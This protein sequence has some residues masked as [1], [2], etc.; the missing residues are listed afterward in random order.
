MP[1][2]RKVYTS[3]KKL[4]AQLL[5]FPV[6]IFHFSVIFSHIQT[7]L[8]KKEV[9]LHRKLSFGTPS[10][11]N[12]VADKKLEITPHLFVHEFHF[13]PKVFRRN[14]ESLGGEG[15]LVKA[16]NPSIFSTFFQHFCNIFCLVWSLSNFWSV[17]NLMKLG[18]GKSNYEFVF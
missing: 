18:F 11:R 13:K 12:F 9:Y 2:S 5:N 6:L 1:K 14:F 15:F 16:W 7:I 17:W 8:I 3:L 4:H 10:G